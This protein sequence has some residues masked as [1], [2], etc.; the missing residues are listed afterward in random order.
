MNLNYWL[1]IADGVVDVLP[2]EDLPYSSRNLIEYLRSAFRSGILDP[3]DGELHSQERLIRRAGDPP[4]SRDDIL[5]MDWLNENVVGRIPPIS[6]LNE[7]AKTVVSL[8]GV[9]KE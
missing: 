9:A 3:F 7:T 4:F 1:G 2:A 8:T 6:S 5:T